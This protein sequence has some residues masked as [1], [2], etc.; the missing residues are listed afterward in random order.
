MKTKAIVWVCG[1]ACLFAC[2][3]EKSET[4]PD[5]AP[6]VYADA[7]VPVEMDAEVKM[8]T[9]E[10]VRPDAGFDDVDSGAG[11]PDADPPPVP[12]AGQ[13]DAGPTPEQRCRV[14][15]SRT[16]EYADINSL[17]PAGYRW[18]LQAA[19]M[20]DYQRL[21]LTVEMPNSLQATWFSDDVFVL[22][23][24]A[25]TGPFQA[26]TRLNLDV[27]TLFANE[28]HESDI[29]YI[30]GL[31]RYWYTES[32]A[33]GRS[34]GREVD[35]L[36]S[37][38]LADPAMPAAFND[39]R[40]E[41]LN[42]SPVNQTEEFKGAALTPD[43]LTMVAAKYTERRY[44]LYEFRRNRVEDSF[45]EAIRLTVSSTGADDVDA[46]LSDD[47]LQLLFASNRNQSYDIFCAWRDTRNGPFQG[48]IVYGDIRDNPDLTGE[49]SPFLL[50]DELFFIRLIPAM[51]AS[52]LYRAIP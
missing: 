28:S 42:L 2:S 31:D 5:A 37:V 48:A 25:T 7:I 6:T 8:D 24:S 27:Q 36:M 46:W 11:F 33:L 14:V 50:N 34:P 35:T 45:D 15:Y 17:I 38:S 52:E 41:H 47:G 20:P 49:Y 1:L 4:A 26:A 10:S 21:Y 43:G 29:Q 22:T 3:E 19:L 30:S 9:G 13:V 12:D 16:E 23:R 40:V 51:R 39:F 18:I 32:R 44:D